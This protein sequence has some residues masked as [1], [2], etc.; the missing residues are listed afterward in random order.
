MEGSATLTTLSGVA[1]QLILASFGL[2][3]LLVDLFSSQERG[4]LSS[5]TLGGIGVAILATLMLWGE[6]GTFFYGM[7][8]VDAFSTFFTLLFL[9][10]ALFTVFLSRQYMRQTAEVN[11]GEYYALLLLATTGMILMVAGRDLLIIFIGLELLSLAQY[12]L[13]GFLRDKARSIESAMK[14]FLLGAFATGFLLYGIA[15][16]YGTTGSTNLSQIHLFASRHRMGN[17]PLFLVGMGLLLVGF[18]FKIASVPFHMWTP[19]VYE[20]APTPIT[21][22]MSTGPK[23]AGFAVLLRIFGSAF[24]SLRPSWTAIFWILAALTMTVGNLSALV[25]GNIKRMLAYSSIAHAGYTLVALTAGSRAGAGGALFYLLVYTFMNFGAFAV[26]SLLV[27]EEEAFVQIDEYRGLGYRYPLLG[28]VMALFML[29]LA[30]IPPTAGFVGK[31]YIFS[32]AV[33]SGYVFL[34]ILGVINS[35][36]SLYY[37]LRV[38]VVMYMQQPAKGVA[39]SFDPALVVALVLA[40]VGILYF[41]LFPGSILPIIQQAAAGLMGG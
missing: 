41:G 7:L 40:S 33:M 25:Q 23:M 39:V 19:D 21:A 27:R 15:L 2:V 5:L 37:Y 4:A 29:S 32:A 8:T 38:V 1:P 26:V 13:A 3:V 20:G 9:L 30:G 16:I 10:V 14:Y 11:N 12:I 28:V 18:G 36:I 24:F 6:Q 34:T 31:F 22:F 17:E 35:L